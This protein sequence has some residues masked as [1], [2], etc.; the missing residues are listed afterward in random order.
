MF[1]R[2]LIYISLLLLFGKSEPNCIQLVYNSTEKGWIA[3]TKKYWKDS[4][5]TWKF[6]KFA[7]EEIHPQ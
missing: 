5:F 7:E 6:I 4:K 1:N 3:W 2:K